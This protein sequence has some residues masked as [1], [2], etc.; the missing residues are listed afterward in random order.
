MLWIHCNM[1]VKRPCSVCHC[2][3][4]FKNGKE[5]QILEIIYSKSWR[6]D[7]SICICMGWIGERGG[8]GVPP[9]GFIWGGVVSSFFLG[10]FYKFLNITSDP[11]L[12]SCRL[13]PFLSELGKRGGFWASLKVKRYMRSGAGR[14]ASQARSSH[15]LQTPRIVPA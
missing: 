1:L 13:A 10:Q 4:L 15:L 12:K 5:K 3:C 9:W 11:Q 6:Q 14:G 2:N 8:W 7:I